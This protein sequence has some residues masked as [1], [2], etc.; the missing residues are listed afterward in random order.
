MK[1]T[2]ILKEIDEARYDQMFNPKTMGN[3]NRKSSDSLKDLT[4]ITQVRNIMDLMPIAFKINNLGGEIVNIEKPY[5]DELEMLAIQ[6]IKDSY[7]IIE[8]AG[9]EID[10]KIVSFAGVQEMPE[11]GTPIEDANGPEFDEVKRRII[12][13]VT[14]GASVRGTFNYLIFKD[15][16]DQL[17][18][19]L[20]QKYNNLMKNT[21]GQFDSNI[22][23][24]FMLAALAQQKNIEGGSEEVSWDEQGAL[25]IHARAIC[26]PML[27]HE[28]VKGLYEILSLQGFGANK[29]RNKQVVRNVDKISNEP[30]DMRYGKFI[31]DALTKVFNESNYDDPR[32]RELFF[33]EIYK[34]DDD[35]FK[36][37]IDNAINDELLPSQ[38]NWANQ[39]MGQI[40]KDLKADDAGV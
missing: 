33:T 21:F 29:E 14:Q 39:V 23:I 24:E 13:A 28:I 19:N 30:E 34:L 31:Y 40:E 15:Y 3:L 11:E 7:P 5:I 38:R 4:G 26:F 16:I 27:V 35:Q 17:N 18:P 10:A 36:L 32:I 9:I 8:Y 1:L 2:K 22:A 6:I 12:N 25:T 37:F 20:I